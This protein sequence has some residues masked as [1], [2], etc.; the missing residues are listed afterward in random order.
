MSDIPP[1]QKWLADMLKTGINE[2]INQLSRINDKL[3]F[4]VVLAIIA[5]VLSIISILR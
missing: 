5:I 2:T 3:T 1:E 4:F